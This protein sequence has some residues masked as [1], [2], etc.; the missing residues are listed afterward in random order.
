M[1]D[2]QT[3][4]NK[5]IYAHLLKWLDKYQ[6]GKLNHKNQEF[7]VKS[8]MDFSVVEGKLSI[9]QPLFV[10]NLRRMKDN[11]IQLCLTENEDSE[12]YYLPIESYFI[13]D[14]PNIWVQFNLENGDRIKIVST[15]TLELAYSDID[16]KMN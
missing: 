1:T 5:E 3:L 6:K 14:E 12:K 16:L 10:F 13:G 7:I 15:R 11:T 2:Y 4:Y 9:G 8:E